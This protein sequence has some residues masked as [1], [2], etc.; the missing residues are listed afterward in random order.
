[1]TIST[2]STSGKSV[3]TFDEYSI[4]LEIEYT[5]EKNKIFVPFIDL[6]ELFNLTKSWNGTSK[7]SFDTIFLIVKN[8]INNDF[9]DT[10]HYGNLKFKLV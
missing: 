10:K 3:L 8:K 5:F 1:M 4:P 6:V 2:L 9:I 7:E